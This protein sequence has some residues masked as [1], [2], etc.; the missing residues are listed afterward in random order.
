MATDGID[1][2]HRR[3]GFVV[4]SSHQCRDERVAIGACE[5]SKSRSNLTIAIAADLALVM[6]DHL[7]A[8]RGALSVHIGIS[9]EVGQLGLLA[10]NERRL[11]LGERSLNLSD[12]CHHSASCAVEAARQL[13]PSFQSGCEPRISS[14]EASTDGITSG[15]VSNV[16]SSLGIDAFSHKD[17]GDRCGRKRLEPHLRATAADGLK[18]PRQIIGQQD[19]QRG[20]RGFLKRLEQSWC[21]PTE[22]V[23]IGKDDDRSGDFQ[24]AAL[25]LSNDLA[26]LIHPPERPFV[27]GHDQIR[28]VQRQRS[29]AMTARSAASVRAQQCGGEAPRRYP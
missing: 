23:S 16:H 10:G 28:M 25:R 3:F 9:V 29:R 14:Q 24:R 20:G 12:K 19:E 18:R 1:A 2:V 7:F 8:T 5:H 21:R 17:L 15:T 22:K 11:R 26:D 4:T 27:A 13:S 6:I